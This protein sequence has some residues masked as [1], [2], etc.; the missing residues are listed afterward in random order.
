MKKI[1]ILTILLWNIMLL[2]AQGVYQ[3][4]GMTQAGGAENSGVMFSRWPGGINYFPQ[5][6]EFKAN[7]GANPALSQLTLYNGKYYGMTRYG[8]FNNVGV[9]FEWD[10]ASDLYLKKLDLSTTTGCNPAGSLTLAGNKFYGM[11]NSGGVNNAGVIF[12]WDPETNIYTKKIDLSIANGNGPDGDLTLVGNKFYGMTSQG[13]NN[14]GGVIF[15]W[16]TVTNM[17][18]KKIDFF[19]NGFTPHGN[20]TMSAGKF[21]GM[22]WQGGSNSVGVIFEW[23]TTTNICIS[24]IDFGNGNDG[25]YPYGSLT[26]NGGKFYG[27]TWRGGANNAG[28]IFEWDPASNIYTKRIDLNSA[29]GSNP[30]GNL[31]WNGSKFYGLTATG[32]SN[33]LGVIFEWDPATNIY[34]KKMDMSAADGSI[35]LGSLVINGSNC[36]GMTQYGGSNGSGVIFQWST[37]TNLYTKEI[38]LNNAKG[39][40]PSGKLITANGKFYGMTTYGGVNNYGVIFEWNPTTNLYTKKTDLSVANGGEPSGSM[41]FYNGKCYGMTMFGGANNWGAIFE[42][43][44][45]TNV[46]TKKFDFGGANGMLPWAG[47]LV[48]YGGKFYGMTAAGGANLNGVIF[49]WDPATNIFVKKIDLDLAGGGSPFGSL[50]YFGSRF[51]GLAKNGGSYNKGTMFEWDPVTNIYIKK[52]DF[53]GTNGS[54]PRG[55]LSVSVNGHMLY[56]M[57]AEGGNYNKGVIFE[58]DP[59]VN[60]ITKYFDFDDVNGANPQGSLTLM[61]NKYY[62]MTAIGGNHNLGVAFEW[63]P[64]TNTYTK[65]KDFAGADGAIPVEGNDFSVMLAP[66]AKGVPGICVGL[67]PVTYINSSNNNAWVP[68]FD[69]AGDVVAEIKANGNNLGLITPSLYVHDG[70]VRE[71]GL[72]RLYLNRNITLTPNVQPSTLV[73][74]RLY[75]KTSEYLALKDAINSNGDPSGINTINDIGIFK[76]NEGCLSAIQQLASPVS[77]TAAGWGLEYVLSASISSFSSFYFGNKAYVALPVTLLDFNGQLSGNNGILSWKTENEQSSAYAAIER[78]TD[79]YNYTVIDKVASF[80]T[81]GTHQYNYTD[82]NINILGAPIVYYRLRLTALNGSFT[83]SGKIALGI[84]NAATVLFYPNPVTDK[85]NLIFRLDKPEQVTGRVLDYSGRLIKQLQW[86]L[87]AGSTSVAVDF[88]GLAKGMYVLELKGKTINEHKQFSKL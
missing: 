49:E 14:G 12:K 4:W 85:A 16:D 75:I 54:S 69:I 81:M 30:H 45:A 88:N 53:D 67:P 25:M 68:I 61:G 83:Y 11:T 66:V 48:L 9:I 28:E 31:S 26:L 42:W 59:T 72:Q 64:A 6:F 78:S 87:V 20:L 82:S 65:M 29:M 35:P 40:N 27:M 57:T 1:I 13:G 8:G 7:P 22:T 77:T 74:I 63:D 79:G 19:L 62:G 84:D 55:S 37:V 73:D 44:P 21:Y 38:D 5:R 80:N 33:N 36:Y 60:T 43:D 17:Y 56:G 71:D 50:T 39:I 23:D 32:G 2:Q 41:T 18:S 52:I 34:S 86:N 70:A 76:N 46:Y 15:E 47:Q 58:W 24:K 3:L 51:Y 10:P